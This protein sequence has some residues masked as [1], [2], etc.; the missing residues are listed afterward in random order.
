VNLLAVEESRADVEQ[1]QALLGAMGVESV[2]FPRYA[3]VGQ[4]HRLP[5]ARLSIALDPDAAEYS[6]SAM[7]DL[8]GVPFL[9]PSAPLG[10]KG[11]TDWFVA[12]GSAL[13]K[14]EEAAAI[15]ERESKRIQPALEAGASFR[16]ARVFVNLA[17]SLAMAFFPVARELGL[18]I[19]GIKAPWAAS[20]HAP[21]LEEIVRHAPETPILVGEGQAFE[22]VNL[23]GKIKPDLYI[24]VGA[25][26]IHA[27]RAGIPVVNLEGV[28][29]LGFAGLE[30]LARAVE[31]ALANRSLS[32]FLSEGGDEPYDPSWLKKSVHWYIKQEV[33]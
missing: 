26:P 27:L 12:L 10:T 21:L 4:V 24:A 33:K 6:G 8:Y 23:L 25:A 18:S 30:R 3:S 14:S 7:E 31:R 32:R 5:E 9:N 2:V 13:G 11:T 17:P 29:L 16:G 1:F 19:A 28:S 20:G 15:V 22:E